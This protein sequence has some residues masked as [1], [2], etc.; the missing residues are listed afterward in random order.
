MEQVM[1][2]DSIIRWMK[3][4]IH[5]IEYMKAVLSPTC[6]TLILTFSS[7]SSSYMFVF[8]KC[9]STRKLCRH[10]S[11]RFRRQH[12]TTSS[13]G[14]QLPPLTAMN[15]KDCFGVLHAKGC[16][17]QSAVSNAM[18]NAKIYSTPTVCS[19]SLLLFFN[20]ILSYLHKISK[21]TESR[22][23]LGI[24]TSLKPGVNNLLP[25]RIY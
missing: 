23:S 2:S 8:R 21:I 12:H 3:I 18:R 1:E 5:S 24:I 25:W 11:I 17:V 22:V 9:M 16:G 20:Q 7:F 6:T 15:V 19:V 10:W 4:I 14:L 13:Y